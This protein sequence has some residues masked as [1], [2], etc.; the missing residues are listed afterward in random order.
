[1]PGHWRRCHRPCR[2]NEAAN[3]PCSSR[4][5]R[6]QA[7]RRPD[8]RS[9]PCGLLASRCCDLRGRRDTGPLRSGPMGSRSGRTRIARLAQAHSG[10]RACERPAGLTDG[11]IAAIAIHA[12]SRFR[13]LAIAAASRRWA[14]F[15]AGQTGIVAGPADFLI[16][17]VLPAVAVIAFWI[18]KQ[19]TPGKMAV[20]TRIVD[21]D[22]GNAASAGQLIGRYFAYFA[23]CIPLGLGILWG[24]FDRRKQG[25]HDKLAGTVAVRQT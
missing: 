16:S 2:K 4:P 25:W 17:W 23:A 3:P 14:Y 9:R 6:S 11:G 12:T 13:H 19:A 1:M 22:S 5:G 8:R 18:I 15:D 10:T 21:A 7:G 20:S 24:A